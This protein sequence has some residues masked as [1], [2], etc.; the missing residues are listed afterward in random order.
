M[1]SA[2]SRTITISFEDRYRC[3]GT[4]SSGFSM[5]APITLGS[6]RRKCK[7]DVGELVAANEPAVFAKPLFDPIVVEDS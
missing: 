2:L 1:V 5:P 4:R 3:K 6:R 7:W